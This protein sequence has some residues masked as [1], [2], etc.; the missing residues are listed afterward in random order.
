M[1]QNVKNI[2][3]FYWKHVWAEKGLVGLMLFGIGA[4]VSID[5]YRPIFFKNFIDIVGS[6]KDVAAA[7]PE[8]IYILVLMFG[9]SVFE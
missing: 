7:K 3:K 5:M 2:A 8:L 6:S 1:K 9:I 4:A